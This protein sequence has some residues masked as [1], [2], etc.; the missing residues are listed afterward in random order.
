MPQP[1][2]MSTLTWHT[3]MNP[4]HVVSSLLEDDPSDEELQGYMDW[5]V[6]NA[7]KENYLYLV[8]ERDWTGKS[9]GNSPLIAVIRD[10]QRA[11]NY[12]KNCNGAVFKVPKSYPLVSCYLNAGNH[13]L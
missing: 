7:D 6:N 2:L 10:R 12:A 5:A 9:S 8:K 4:L 3:D 13:I 1:D 11:H